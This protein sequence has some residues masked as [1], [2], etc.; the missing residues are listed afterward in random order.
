MRCHMKPLHLT[1]MVEDKIINKILVDGGAAL[2]ILP[3]SMLWRFGRNVED[4]IPHN[5]VVADFCGKPLDSKGAICL[6]VF[7][8][9]KRRPTEFLVISSLANF[10]M[11]LG[12]EWIHKV[13]AIKSPV[14]QKLFFWNEDGILEMVEADQSSY[15]IYVAFAYEKAYSS[16]MARL[17][18]YIADNKKQTTTV[19]VEIGDMTTV[20]V[21]IKEAA[22][23]IFEIKDKKKRWI[24]K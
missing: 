19:V 16:F 6:D 14:H 13:V 8:G 20:A 10:N 18:T 11:L 7:V 3:R 15:G 23:V 12:K 2:N 1:T 4:L 9:S 17:S 5:I 24:L 22:I 21:K